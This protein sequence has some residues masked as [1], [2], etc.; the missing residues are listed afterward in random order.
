MLPKIILIILFLFPPIASAM[1]MDVFQDMMKKV[2]NKNFGAVE[3]FL[4]E[5][6]TSLKKDPEYYV[7]LSICS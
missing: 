3:Q 1:D 5:N 2:N 4:E 6:R 7:I